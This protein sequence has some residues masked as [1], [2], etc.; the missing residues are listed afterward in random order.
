MNMKR[1]Y[2]VF[3]FLM[4][5]ALLLSPMAKEIYAAITVV[6]NVETPSAPIKSKQVTLLANG[7]QIST[8]SNTTTTW[9]VSYYNQGIFQIYSQANTSATQF[10]D[11]F[12]DQS[13]DN[14]RW[15]TAGHFTQWSSTATDNVVTLNPIGRYIR[16][17][18]T[19]AGWTAA[20]GGYCTAGVSAVFKR[21]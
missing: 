8:S 15:A 12:I 7:T 3:G 16:V 11:F 14:S 13:Q 1:T 18:W 10:C 6:G 4:A 17:R 21:E 20:D 9:D 19:M 5:L 2:I